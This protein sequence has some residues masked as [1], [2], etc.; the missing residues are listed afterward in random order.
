[1][2]TWLKNTYKPLALK[3][4]PYFRKISYVIPQLLFNPVKIHL[5]LHF[6]PHAKVLIMRHDALGDMI[7]TLPIFELIKQYHPQL[8]IHV[9]CTVNNKVLIED[10][11]YIDAIH[12][13]PISLA[14]KPLAHIQDILSLRKHSFDIIINCLTSSSSQNGVLV[15]LIAKKNSIRVSSYEGD[16][17]ACY[18]NAQSY[19]SADTINMWEK[20]FELITDVLG[21]D[22]PQEELRMPQLLIDSS[23]EYSAKKTLQ[24]LE[25]F[26]K[27]FIV[28]NLSVRQSK[29]ACTLQQ[30]E[31]LIAGL[32]N[33]SIHVLLLWMPADKALTDQLLLSNSPYTLAYPEGRHLFEVCE[34]IKKALWV[35]TPDT[36]M[37]HIATAVHT[38]V[39]A[40]YQEK[41]TIKQGEW[42]P[43][44]V[45]FH[46][47]NSPK[48]ASICDIEAQEILSKC[49]D[50]HES[51]LSQITR[52]RS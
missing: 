31:T 21:I 18:Y 52:P 14:Q 22:S 8:E 2:A 49:L 37:I 27:S 20:M 35:F 4:T 5:P 34:V 17:Y 25:L 47:I 41:G 38:P 36:G 30:Y 9:A 50:F 33:L 39:F 15:N 28:I 7:V 32:N 26:D 23:Y 29:N 19:K 43:Y 51:I 10:N 46:Y 6:K 1:M 3:F 42:W 11:P 12:I 40:V 16:Q 48:G 44:M 13:V 24:Q 45:P